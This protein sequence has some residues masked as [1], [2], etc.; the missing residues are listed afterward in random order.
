VDSA[1]YKLLAL[2]FSPRLAVFTRFVIDNAEIG[3]F[4]PQTPALPESDLVVLRAE[5]AQEV[6]VRDFDVISPEDFRRAL[7]YANLEWRT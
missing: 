3:L 4:T 2:K 5:T 6:F 7:D 1:E